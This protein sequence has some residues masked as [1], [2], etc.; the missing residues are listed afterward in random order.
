MM[1]V[2]PK[3]S[4]SVARAVEAL[5][6]GK[7]VIVTDDEKRENEGDLVLAAQYATPEKMAFMIRHTGGVACLSLSQKIADQLDLPSVDHRHSTSSS[8][9]P[10]FTVSIEAAKGVTTGISAADRST[11]IQ[12]AIHPKAKPED[13][14]RPGHVFPIRA[15]DGG[16]LFRA[17]HTEASVDLCRLS[18]LREGAVI[19]ELMHENGTMMRFPAIQVFA[20]KYKIPILTIADLIAYRRKNESIVTLEATT[21]LETTYGT[22]DIFVYQDVLQ[23]KEHIALRMG[24]SIRPSESVLVRVHS[25][26]ITGDV[27]HSVHCDCGQQLDLAMKQISEEGKGVILYLRQEGRDIGLTNKIRAYA[28][29]HLGMDTVDAN[30]SLGFGDDLR[31]YGIGAQIL[32]DLGVSS[33]RLLTNNPK[34]IVALEGYGLK[35][36]EQIPI[37]ITPT[38]ESQKKYLTTK[39]K[40]MKHTLKKV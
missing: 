37:E 27:F 19:S 8:I 29:Q 36:L 31:E 34:K 17:G 16:V 14:S 4:S 39:K 5:K 24:G 21:A 25:E 9:R 7:F 26:C 18:G 23:H 33:M 6:S 38:S 1:N 3:H 22:W 10:R 2:L 13:L 32:K 20:K 28:Q 30:R 15:Q 35:I 40:R 11:T 12:A